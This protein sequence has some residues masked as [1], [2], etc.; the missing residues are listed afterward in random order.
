MAGA[1][2]ARPGLSPRLL[3][4]SVCID[5]LTRL[6]EWLAV[7]DGVAEVCEVVLDLQADRRAI[8]AVVVLASGIADHEVLR[9]LVVP[10]LTADVMEAERAWWHV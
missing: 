1:S 3:E 8:A 7:H 6:Q 4:S 10:H 9:A 5:D 2:D